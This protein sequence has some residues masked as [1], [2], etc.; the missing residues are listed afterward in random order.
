MTAEL[1]DAVTTAYLWTMRWEAQAGSQARTCPR[2]KQVV[3]N[4]AVV[5]KKRWWDQLPY[6]LEQ[7][8]QDRRWFLGLA[9]SSPDGDVAELAGGLARALGE[10]REAA[11]GAMSADLCR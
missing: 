11:M 6:Q 9:D 2:A 4:I 7:L 5:C 3:N 8:E 10:L 1:T